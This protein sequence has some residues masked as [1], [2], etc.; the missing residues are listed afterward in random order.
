MGNNAR[1]T[2]DHDSTVVFI[3]GDAIG[4]GDEELGSNLMVNFIYHLGKADS[5]PDV[6]V[7]MNAGVKLVVEGSEVLDELHELEGKGVAILACGT[8]LR[9]FH[10]EEKQE[11]GITSN[12]PE[13]VK[14]LTGAS[15][16]IT[17]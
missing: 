6:I 4:R 10:L 2:E 9:Y 8:C 11:V 1:S 17:V 12:M 13:I 7:L 15:R 16:I 14:T 3:R 5:F